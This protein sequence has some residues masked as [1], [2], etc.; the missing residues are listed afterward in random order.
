V[1]H[2]AKPDLD[3]LERAVWDALAGLIYVDDAAVCSSASRKFYA[4]DKEPPGVRIRAERIEQKP[5]DV[6]EGE[7]RWSAESR[8]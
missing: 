2:L 4:T 3:K 1:R 6:V 8:P 7:A 5:T